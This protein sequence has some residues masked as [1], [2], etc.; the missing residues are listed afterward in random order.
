MNPVIKGIPVDMFLV[1]GHEE[2]G[3][4][5]YDSVKTRVENST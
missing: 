1:T 5:E 4:N 2:F 3:V